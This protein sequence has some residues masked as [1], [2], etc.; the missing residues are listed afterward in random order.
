MTGS[1]IAAST[2]SVNINLGGLHSPSTAVVIIAALTVLSIAPSV[3]I[4]FTGFTRIF[5]VLGLTRSGLG[6][7]NTPPNQV[8]AGI[9]L[10][11]SLFVMAPVLNQMDHDALQPYLRGS[12]TA[13][14]AISEGEVPLKTWM[15]KQTGNSELQMFATDQ[16]DSFTNPDTLPMTVVVPSFVIS[17]VQSAFTIGFVIFI[18]FLVIDLVVSSVLMSMGMF[19]LPPTLVSLP[20]KILLFVLVDGWALVVHSLITSFH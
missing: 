2:P 6:L 7:Q 18:P 1:L 14:Q 15:L 10:F 13:T 8:I 16:H 11:I 19:M 12:L 17:E 3:L 20:F 5:I 9:A 4:L